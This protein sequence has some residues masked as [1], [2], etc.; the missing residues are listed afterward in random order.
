MDRWAIYID[1]EG[2]SA[3]YPEGDDVLWALNRLMLAIYKIGSLVYIKPPDR[4]FA[5]QM[6]DGFLIGSDFH[7][8][9]LDRPA[10]IAIVLMKFIANFGLFARAAIAEGEISDIVGCYPIEVLDNRRD[11]DYPT[12]IMGDGLMTIFPIMGTAL[13]NVVGVDKRAP[14]G[15]LLTV[16]KEF[17]NR[18]S[19]NVISNVIVGT[20]NIGI[21]WVH[22][23]SELIT[24]I[25]TKAMLEFPC[26]ENLEILLGKYIAKY[27]LP[28]EWVSS[29]RNYMRISV[30]NI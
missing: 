17:R 18:L 2:F 22:T 23:E 9:K 1:I 21:D 24:Y 13:V 5:H 15:P 20:P 19:S 6:G 26:P 8:P 25:K 4:L 7:E 27:K 16:P 29:C 28:D 10:A 3:L 30:P 11:G 12:A 14:K